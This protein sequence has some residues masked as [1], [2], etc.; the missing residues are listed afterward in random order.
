MGP[1]LAADGALVDLGQ[2]ALAEAAHPA[3]GQLQP[4]AGA[5]RRAGLLQRLLDVAQPA[6]V[7]DGVLAQ[8]AAQRVLVDVLQPRPGVLLAQGLG[9]VLVLLEV[10]D[11]VDGLRQRPR[12]LPRRHR[13]AHALAPAQLGEP[14]LQRPLELVGLERQVHVAEEL[15]GH[16]RELGALVGVQRRHQPRHRR[17]APGQLL[18]QLVE[19]LR[20]LGS[21]QPAQQVAVA[22]LEALEVVADVLA[23]LLAGGQPVEVGEQVAHALEVPGRHRP[24]RPGEAPEGRLRDVAAELVDE[25][26]EVAPRLPVGEVVLLEL[27]EPGRGV[28]RQVVELLAL[29][30]GGLGVGVEV[31]RGALAVQDVG[32]ALLDVAERA[33][34]AQAGQLAAAR[35]LDA[36]AQVVQPPDLAAHPALEQRPQ[37]VLGVAPAQQLVADLG[38][39]VVGG[40]V[41]REGV[42]R[43]AP[44]PEPDAHAPSL[45]DL[46]RR[47]YFLARP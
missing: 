5:A 36:A 28:R 46:L 30:R 22:L 12:L 20:A 47:T 15:L 18:E 45:P 44:L 4:P 42:L 11:P 41:G 21:T 8:R 13:A 16:L 24:H 27:G 2:R 39:D 17:H 29:G 25:V 40:D 26:A 6:Q 38:Q 9:E 37:R 35:L 14:A 31:Q 33:L 1:D 23:A 32:E 7:A 43:A 10:L 34:Q 19:G 3:R